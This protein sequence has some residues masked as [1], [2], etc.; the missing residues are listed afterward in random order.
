[1]IGLVSSKI[2]EIEY[3]GIGFAIPSD[4]MLPIIDNLMKNGYVTGRVRLG[5]TVS[6]YEDYIVTA[7][8]LPGNVYVVEV[9]PGTNAAAQGV[10]VG[11]IITA[12]DGEAINSTSQMVGIIRSHKAGDTIKLSIYRK[13][14]GMTETQTISVTLYEDKGQ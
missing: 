9:V 6:E 2:A 4:E 5:I 7:N 11:D 8:N 12:V 13:K 10:L 1:V 14:G 3:E